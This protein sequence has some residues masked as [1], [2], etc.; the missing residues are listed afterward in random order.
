MDAEK[1]QELWGTLY[2]AA[3]SR[4]G[5]DL[6]TDADRATIAAIVA[7]VPETVA[8]K[9]KTVAAK[10]AN[11]SFIANGIGMELAPLFE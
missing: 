5:R 9:I 3:D 1:I 10:R 4:R 7:L 6:L 11:L 8:R 2:D